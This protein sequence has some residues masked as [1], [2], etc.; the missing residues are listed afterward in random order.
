MAEP[1]VRK[2][3]ALSEDLAKSLSAA[4]QRFVL[5]S[6]TSGQKWDALMLRHLREPLTEYL[7]G[8]YNKELVSRGLEPLSAERIAI[9]VREALGSTDD[10]RQTLL[11][12]PLAS[13]TGSAPNAVAITAAGRFS[14]GKLVDRVHQLGVVQSLIRV[15]QGRAAEFSGTGGDGY[16]GRKRWRTSVASSRHSFLDFVEAGPDGT[17]SVAPGVRW[18]YPRQEPQFASAASGCRCYVEYLYINPESGEEEWL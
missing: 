1:L 4:V 5:S 12:A 2:I 6:D 17:W 9:L 18:E 13:E 10:I 3:D 15:L 14:L 16:T 8:T 11:T 7:N